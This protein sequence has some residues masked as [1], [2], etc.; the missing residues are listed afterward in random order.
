V[1]D[2]DLPT[3]REFLRL[4]K[5]NVKRFRSLYLPH[6]MSYGLCYG[7]E[8]YSAWSEGQIPAVFNRRKWHSMWKK[9]EYSNEKLK[10]RLGWAPAVPMEEGLKRYFSSCVERHA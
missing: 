7:W 2:D 8:R 6:M 3:S 5:R 10:I 9:T 4:Y 1:V